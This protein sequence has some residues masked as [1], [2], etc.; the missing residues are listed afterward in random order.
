MAAGFV[1][2]VSHDVDGDCCCEDQDIV[3]AGIDLH[4]IG[5][6]QPEPLLRDLGDPVAA[7]L[8]AIVVVEDVALHLEVRAAPQAERP[9]LAEGVTS[10]FLIRPIDWPLASSVSMESLM[11]SIRS[12]MRQSA[13]PLASSKISVARTRSALPPTLK[14]FWPRSLSL[15]KSSPMASMR[16]VIW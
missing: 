12:W 4:T 6:A 10:A 15:Q 16:C 2:R 8:D 5:V 1:A 11:R 3:L 7:L 14:T 13:R 9:A